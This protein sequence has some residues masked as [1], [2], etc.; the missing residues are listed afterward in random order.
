MASVEYN[1]LTAAEKNTLAHTIAYQG[2]GESQARNQYNLGPEE[3][4][5]LMLENEFERCTGC[6]WYVEIFQLLT[7]DC[8]IKLCDECEPRKEQ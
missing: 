1:Q 3:I 5:E 2:D 6:D 4:D 7:D 8:V